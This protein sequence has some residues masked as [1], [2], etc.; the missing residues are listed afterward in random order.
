M[1]RERSRINHLDQRDSLDDLWNE[2]MGELEAQ[3]HVEGVDEEDDG[4]GDSAANVEL[5]AGKVDLVTFGFKREEKELNRR[6]RVV[7]R[8]RQD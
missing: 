1:N 6:V 4:G 8:W 2:A 7:L 5:S 3:L